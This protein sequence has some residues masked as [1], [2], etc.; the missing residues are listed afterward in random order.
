MIPIRF[1]V[2]AHKIIRK[3]EFGK[4]ITE[5]FQWLSKYLDEIGFPLPPEYYISGLVLLVTLVFIGSIIPVFIIHYLI[6]GIYLPFSII[7]SI[8]A[9]IILALLTL[10]ITLYYPIFKAKSIKSSIEAN[11]PFI[12]LTMTSLAASGFSVYNII[13]KTHQLTRNIHV[14]RSMERIIKQVTEGKDVSDALFNE[15]MITSSYTLATTYE[16]LASLSQT[17]VGVMSFLEKML[18]EN[19]FNLES[20]LRETIEK[21]SILMETYVIIALVFPLLV[22][23]AQLFLGQFGGLPLPPMALMMILAFLV[24]PVI[25][26]ILLLIADSLTSEVRIG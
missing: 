9:S 18:N 2:Y 4:K 13:E 19:I 12:L 17:G 6:L 22:M 20:K 26:I 7:L 8:I 14:K 21:L 16:G 24:L 23:I 10:A 25:F 1:T 3:T 15:S 11:M 5:S